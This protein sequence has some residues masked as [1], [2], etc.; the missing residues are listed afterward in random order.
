MMGLT[1]PNGWE[2]IDEPHPQDGVVAYSEARFRNTNGF[3]IVI[4]SEVAEDAADYKIEEDDK[5]AVEVYNASQDYVEG[6]SYETEAT[7]KEAAREVME[8]FS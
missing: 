8:K 2:E 7:A 5:Y 6:D 3:E 1:L 4:W